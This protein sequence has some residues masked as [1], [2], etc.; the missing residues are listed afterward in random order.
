MVEISFVHTQ[1]STQCHM[2]WKHVSKNF[3]FSF[4]LVRFLNEKKNVQNQ[5]VFHIPRKFWLFPQTKNGMEWWWKKKHYFSFGTWD[6]S[7][8]IIKFSFQFLS[9]I[10][11]CVCAVFVCATAWSGV[12]GVHLMAVNCTRNSFPSSFHL[13]MT[14]SFH[15]NPQRLVLVPSNQRI[16]RRKKKPEIFVAQ[17]CIY[18]GL[19]S[20]T[21]HFNW[22]TTI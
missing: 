21:N 13:F 12:S 2:K 18:F 14:T 17:I 11:V 20:P 19:F 4:L 8:M 6:L 1:H 15:L 7:T 3:L 22:Q 5:I 9:Q 10:F 16:R